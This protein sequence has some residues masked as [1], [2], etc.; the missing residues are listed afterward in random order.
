MVSAVA[1][2]VFTWRDGSG[3]ETTTRVYAS[4][5]LSHTAIQAA[6]STL[7]ARLHAI[8][9]CAIVEQCIIYREIL[10]L[11]PEQGSLWPTGLFIF[12]CSPGQFAQITVPGVRSTYLNTSTEPHTITITH[13]TIADFLE[14]IIA[15]CCN[16][17]GYL[18]SSFNEAVVQEP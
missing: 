7:R 1:E 13:P 5:A 4:S 11:A 17:F 15:R 2:V 12:A 18:V 14:R 6:A 16:P 3:S 8:S 9:G 10:P